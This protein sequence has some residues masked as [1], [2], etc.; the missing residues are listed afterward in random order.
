MNNISFKNTLKEIVAKKYEYETEAMHYLIRKMKSLGYNMNAKD[1]V[2]DM[3]NIELNRIRTSDKRFRAHQIKNELGL[4]YNHI[5][6]LNK[7]LPTRTIE[8]DE[9]YIND[10]ERKR[11]ISLWNITKV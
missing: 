2:L 7:T 3:K 9:E 8:I 11:S 4:L 1:P 10:T 5:K 6:I